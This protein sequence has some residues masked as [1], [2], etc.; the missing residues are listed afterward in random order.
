MD[1][2]VRDS[3]EKM[4]NPKTLRQNLV[5]AAVFLTAYEMLKEA[6][7]DRLRGFYSTE[8]TKDGPEVGAGYQREVRGL[9]KKEVIACAKWFRRS[10]ALT[11]AD[12]VLLQEIIQ[13]RNTAAHHLPAVL[14]SSE[15]Q[16]SLRH[17]HAI[18]ELTAKLDVWWIKSIEV[19]TDPAFDKER[20]T[21]DQLNQSYS[22]RMVFMSLL[23]QV[24][25]GNDAT[26]TEIY[27]GWK[28]GVSGPPK[29]GS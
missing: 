29:S 22:I 2:E 11:D 10:D 9:D 7:V 19:E 20:P 27:E 18:Y 21:E 3:W 4:L 15:K 16:F 28:K 6:L 23:I 14:G 1:D 26:L 5:T 24:A 12:L 17:L 13:H 25:E 8:W